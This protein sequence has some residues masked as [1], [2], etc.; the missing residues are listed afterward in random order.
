MFSLP[1]TVCL[2]AAQ[3]HN[4]YYAVPLIVVVSLVYSATRHEYMHAIINGAIRVAIWITVFM[5]IIFAVLW[6]VGK[7]V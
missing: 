6:G 7:L 5:L 4:L 3:I 1:L 2:L